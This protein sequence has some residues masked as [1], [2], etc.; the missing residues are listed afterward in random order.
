MPKSKELTEFER[1]EIVGLS[2]INLSVRKIA[3][4]LLIAKST[5][6]DVINKYRRRGLITAA[7]RSGRPPILT[8]RNTRTL[9]KMVK[10]D[11]QTSLEELTEDFNKTLQISVCSKTVKR[12]LHEEGYYG[13]VGKKKPLV[14][15]INRKKRLFWCYERR[16]WVE[17]WEKVIFSD[18]S[19]FVLFSNDSPK[20]VWRKVDERYNK[21]CLI[22]TV[23]QSAGVMVW[24]CF[25]KDKVGPLVFIEGTITGER[26]LQLLNNYLLPFLHELG[27]EDEY[28][29]QDDN[30]PVHTAR[31]VKDWK[32]ENLDN[33][34]PWPAQSPDLNPIEN[35]WDILER[36]VRMHNPLPKNKRELMT[37]LEDEWHKLEPEKLT[38]LIDSMP[39]RVKA[40]IKS[41]GN[42]T[43]Y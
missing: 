17:E 6:Q 1:D 37:I 35:L 2:K 11:R 32:E 3:E 20:F 31:I 10:K 13:R 43:K 26:Y 33:W 15:E 29:F 38:K 30:A 41:K 19:R 34:L 12:K 7:P 27:N 40:V 25:C 39:R 21:D 14:S 9:I 24:G 36:K 18:E 28:I 5:V 42:P 16:N 4:V 22:P 8:P 23:K